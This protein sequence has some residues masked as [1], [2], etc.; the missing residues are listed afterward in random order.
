LIVARIVALSSFVSRGHV[1]LRA[2]VPALERC[3]HDVIALPTVTFSSHA[4]YPHVAGQTLEPAE[5]ERMAAA[6]DANGWLTADMVITGYLPSPAHVSFAGDLVDRIRCRSPGATYVCD[7]VLG[8]EP[9]GLYLPVETAA[10]VKA[11]LLPRAQVITPNAFELGWLANRSITNVD[12]ATKAAKALNIP[13]VLATSIAAGPGHLATV[14]ASGGGAV[15]TRVAR[16][17]SA[18]SGTG[19]LLT[20]LFAGLLASGSTA[21]EALAVSSAWLDEILTTNADSDDLSLDRLY[22]APPT[23]LFVAPV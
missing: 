6:L 14:L 8:D 7:P 20:G 4:A 9:R 18:P 12:D 23:G 10:L 22:A 15:L 19:D 17:A 11:V 5:L 2:L 13:M 1:G 21:Q 16:R 3:G